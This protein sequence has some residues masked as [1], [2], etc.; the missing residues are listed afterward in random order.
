M[1]TTTSA[2]AQTSTSSDQTPAEQST[3]PGESHVGLMLRDAMNTWEGR[4]AE[5]KRKRSACSFCFG[6]CLTG[7]LGSG[8]STSIT[9]ILD[10]AARSFVRIHHPFMNV[11]LCFKVGI[12]CD[13][14]STTDPTRLLTDNDRQLMAMYVSFLSVILLNILS[15]F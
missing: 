15:H 1:S 13:V 10:R 3:S 5:R 12:A 4:K 6:Y 2:T 14:N 7:L 8:N 9:D 11:V